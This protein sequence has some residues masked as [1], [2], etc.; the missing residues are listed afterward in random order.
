DKEGVGKSLNNIGSIY[1]EQRDNDKA[2]EYFSRSLE[3]QKQIGRKLG[4][5]VTM[6]NIANIYA[7]KTDFTKALNYYNQSLVIFKEISHKQG[8]ANS[9][10]N[11]GNIYKDKKDLDT[12]LVFYNKG[13]NIQDEIGD[14]IGLTGTLV[15]IG[16]I[17][18]D[19][20]DFLKSINY[21]KKAL[22]LA[23]KNGNLL[24]V[25]ESSLLLFK[26]YKSI[27]KYSL[28]LEMHELFVNSSD[29][30]I[31]EKTQR[32]ILQQEFKYQYD[33]LAAID[34]IKTE[35]AKKVYN[36][37]IIAQQAEIRLKKNQQYVLI[38]GLFFV[39]IFA[40]FIYNRLRVIRLQKKIIEQQKELVEE[41]HKEITDSINYAERIQRSFLATTEILDKHLKEYF[42]FFQPKDV[43]SG[44]FYWA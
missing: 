9:L 42:V 6:I 2:L 34:S 8:I 41:K 23:R 20:G 37:K 24:R 19:Q 39:L 25:K 17:Y 40:G 35:E 43:V 10:F 21:S 36:S 18:Y 30:L 33:K 22:D 27:K 5:A 13:L 15:N 3:I 38:G 4:V 14:E 29:S 28:A 7:A 31:N 11:I 1:S 16:R 32:D 44:D 26:S 12:A